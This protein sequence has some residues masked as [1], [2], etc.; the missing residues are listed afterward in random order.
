MQI[1]CRNIRGHHIA[2]GA[3]PQ[4]PGPIFPSLSKHGSGPRPSPPPG[5]LGLESPAEE[6]SKMRIIAAE[7]RAGDADLARGF[8]TRHV[9]GVSL[10]MWEEMLQVK[11]P[12]PEAARRSPPEGQGTGRARGRRARR[13]PVFPLQ[14]E[15]R[16]TRRL[17]LQLEQTPDLR[18]T[19]ILLA[20]L[21]PRTKPVRPTR[22]QT[23]SLENQPVPL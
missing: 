4:P 7:A 14:P 1:I 6:T 13:C 8:S 12:R 17:C 10:R 5:A 18:A 22:K 15:C 19:G 3:G 20:N 21:H 11:G 2:A 16:E 9:R 23:G